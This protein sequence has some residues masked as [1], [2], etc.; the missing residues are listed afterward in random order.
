MKMVGYDEKIL[1][2]EQWMKNGTTSA[3]NGHK[4]TKIPK[5]TLK[6]CIDACGALL[7]CASVDWNINTKVC[8]YGQHH[9]EPQMLAAT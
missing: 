9:G 1:G 4:Q 2:G 6:A 3:D 7:T 5:K 8:Y